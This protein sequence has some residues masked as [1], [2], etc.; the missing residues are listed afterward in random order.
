MLVLVLVLPMVLGNRI[1][2]RL[3]R[4]QAAQRA[5]GGDADGD[6][7]G[8]VDLASPTPGHA[9]STTRDSP[10]QR[11]ALDHS[12]QST[13]EQTCTPPPSSPLACHL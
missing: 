5:A 12:P 6:A 13:P 8:D 7:G 9:A 3:L 10:L 1:L 11:A 2:A 4:E